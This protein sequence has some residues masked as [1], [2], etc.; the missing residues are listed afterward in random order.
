MSPGVLFGWVS[1]MEEIEDY[2]SRWG[3]PME[4]SAAKKERPVMYGTV[5]KDKREKKDWLKA[6]PAAAATLA[7]AAAFKQY[8]G[9]K[10]LL[11]NVILYS[12]TGATSGWLPLV[13]RDAFRTLKDKR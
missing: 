1:E 3:T 2:Y 12:G 10:D 13:Y 4:K 7:G 5:T 6:L 9:K 8:R 11:K